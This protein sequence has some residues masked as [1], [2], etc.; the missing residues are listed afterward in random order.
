MKIDSNEWVT[1][2]EDFPQ[3]KINKHGEVINLKMG[4]YIKGSRRN[5]YVRVNINGHPKSIHRIVYEKFVGE[6]PNGYVIDHIDGQRDNND[7]TNLRLI[8]Q[9]ENMYHAQENGHNGQRPVI[10]YDF[11]KRKITEYSSIAKAARAMNVT[12]AAIRRAIVKGGSS[13]GYKWAF[14]NDDCF[15]DSL[16]AGKS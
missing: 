15:D 14:K 1:I 16:T 3:Y 4:R 12:N 13:C 8:T 11:D 2:D 6:I 7:V 9:S 5:G 10:Q